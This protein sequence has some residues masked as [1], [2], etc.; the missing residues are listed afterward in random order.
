MQKVGIRDEKLIQDKIAAE[1]YE[2]QVN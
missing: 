1:E 2:K